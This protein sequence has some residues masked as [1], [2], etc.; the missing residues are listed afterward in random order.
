MVRGECLA[1]GCWPKV[2]ASVPCVGDFVKGLV[3]DAECVRKVC[4]I[5]HTTTKS[6]ENAATRREY[7]VP[8]IL[9]DLE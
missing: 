4:K 6:Y 2:F 5:T 7:I 8:F 3:D 9:V 1:D